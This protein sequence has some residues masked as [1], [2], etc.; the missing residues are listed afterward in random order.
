MDIKSFSNN[1]LLYLFA[2]LRDGFVYPATGTDGSSCGTAV[3]STKPQILL[4]SLAPCNSN[5]GGEIN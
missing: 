5:Q 1:L 4:A 3:S 2:T